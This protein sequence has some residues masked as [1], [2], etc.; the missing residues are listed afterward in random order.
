MIKLAPDTRLVAIDVE[1]E[2]FDDKLVRVRD[3]YSR[4]PLVCVQVATGGEERILEPRDHCRQLLQQ[5]LEEKEYVI[6]GHNFAFDLSVLLQEWPALTNLAREAVLSGRLLDTMAM[7]H[8]REPD[9]DRGGKRLDR[10]ARK[11]L[12]VRIVK[13]ATQTSFRRGVPLTE[14]QKKYATDDALVTLQLAK[15]LLRVPY[16]S[17]YER[18]DQDRHEVPCPENHNL[19]GSLDQIFSAAAV[20]SGVWIEPNGWTI[21]RDLLEKKREETRRDAQKVLGLLAKE[22]LA[23]PDRIPKTNPVAIELTRAGRKWMWVTENDRWERNFGGQAQAKP[24]RWKMD[25][26]RIRQA[27]TADAA[28]NQIKAPN[29]PTGGIQTSYKFWKPYRPVLSPA[30]QA[31]M[32]YQRAHKLETA[33]FASWTTSTTGELYPQYWI[34][35]TATLRDASSKPN[36]QQVPK[37]LRPILY[38]PGRVI[39]GAD[40]SALEIYTLVHHMLVLGIDGPLNAMLRSGQDPH[41]YAASLLAGG[42]PADH[43]KDTTTRQSAKAANFG[44]PGGLGAEKFYFLGRSSYNLDWTLEEA[45]ALRRAYLR[46]FWDVAE[47]VGRLRELRPGQLRPEGVPLHEWLDDLG[48]DEWPGSFELAQ[49]MDEGR[50]FDVELPTGMRV[51]AR[52]FTQAANLPF[53]HLGAVIITLAKLHALEAGLNVVGAVHDALYVDCDSGVQNTREATA[54]LLEECMESAFRAVCPLAP[55]QKV[56]A[57]LQEHFF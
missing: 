29:T 5:F 32:D 27:F 14:A 17:E 8:L 39:V 50:I 10:L 44:L 41:S 13:D 22:G 49:A 35:G 30:V 37:A 26:R 2:P 1:T 34:P 54:G 25:M 48:F 11:Y 42:T 40:Y 43:G 24:G 31:L 21:D 6:V 20:A 33:F 52:N 51:P 55:P 56:E 57:E 4:P 47:Y 15:H 45:T 7:A 46:E 16:G 3:R 38:R 9:V 36:V 19:P 53:Q 28:A 12:N 18:H 23:V